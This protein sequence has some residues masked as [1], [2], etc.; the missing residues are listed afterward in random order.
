MNRMKYTKPEM[1][2]FVF[3]SEDIITAST[4]PTPE[5]PDYTPS[6]LGLE[7]ILELGL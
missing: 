4:T 6:A 7:D 1:E 2:I 3:G 5:L